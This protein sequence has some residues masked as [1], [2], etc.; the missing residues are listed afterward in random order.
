MDIASLLFP[1]APSY[2]TGLLGEEEAARLQGQARQAGLLN[3][4][5]GLLAAGGP[6]AVRPGLGQGLIQ[7]LSAGQQA[8]Q[9]VYSQRLQ[10]MEL[11]RKI[12]EQR[13]QEQ[14]RSMMGS[15][16]QPSVTPGTPA[17]F[18]EESDGNV[19]IGQ[20]P[21]A[22]RMGLQIDP[23]RL[24]AA[25]ALSD[26]PLESLKAVP[27]IVQGLRKAG[28]APGGMQQEISPFA[29]FLASDNPNI[30]AVA[31]QYDRAYKAG[32]ID[33]QQTGRAV[34][35]MARMA[36]T[37]G[38]PI[39]E[40]ASYENYRRQEVAEGRIPKSYEDFLVNLRRSGA[41]TQTT[42]VVQPG[43][44]TPGT[45]GMNEVDKAILQTGE[46][47]Q[48]LDRI[49]QMYRPEFLQTKFQSA[50]KLISLGE[51]LGREPSATERENLS[52]YSRFKQDSV[53]QL[54]Q[55]INAITG[56]AIGQGEEAERIKAGVP[57][58]G[59]GLFDGDSPTE[60]ASKLE[61]TIRNL[62]MVEARLHYIKTSGLK[63]SDVKI[64]QMPD[65]MRKRKTQ[66]VR[67][68]GLD[69]N[70]PEDREVLRNRLAS[71]FGLLR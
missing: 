11:A 28:L 45:A 14:L 68:F 37:A 60:F 15:I 69:E 19:Q 23:Q 56:A 54:N 63:L 26:R 49:A 5:L 17:Q 53:A 9:N 38:K 32:Q 18:A 57:N 35:A 24:M 66:L 67:D 20:M 30:K 48:S 58:P 61:N 1:Q 7:G 47:L 2:A 46:R 59:S 27:E 55:Y 50:Q 22:A 12:A 70:K 34:E 71:E 31:Q 62:R 43:A 16:I 10:E 36:E 51:K 39:S 13:R 52:Q 40:I 3:L 44:V 42:T 21:T 41:A 8:Y 4:G 33:D 6:A 64:D 29:V 25:A 65:I